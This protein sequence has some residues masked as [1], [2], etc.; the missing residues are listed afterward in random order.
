MGCLLHLHDTQN[1][2][3]AAAPPPAPL[4]PARSHRLVTIPPVGW[5]NAAHTH[6]VP[7]LGTL[8]SEWDAGAAACRQLF[9]TLSS[10]EA[11]ADQLAAIAAHHGFDGWLINIENAVDPAHIPNLLHFLRRGLQLPRRVGWMHRAKH[12]PLPTCDRLL[13]KL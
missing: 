11:A 7:I 8:I 10:A 6:G 1:R 12:R 9:G 2:P 13:C 4:A 3:H 5:V